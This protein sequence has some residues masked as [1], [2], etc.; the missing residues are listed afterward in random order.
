MGLKCGY[1]FFRRYVLGEKKPP[2]AALAFGRSDDEAKNVVYDHKIET[3]ETLGINE[4]Q[5][6][7]AANFEQQTE[8]VEDWK[9]DKPGDLKDTGVRLM[10]AWREQIAID[11]H[12]VMTQK[13][14][15]VPI[16]YRKRE[17]G[18]RSFL[19]EGVLDLVEDTAAV[20]VITDNKTSAQKWGK[21]RVQ[22]STQALFYGVAA[23]RDEDLRA[24]EVDPNQ[25]HFHVAVKSKTPQLQHP[26]QDPDMVRRTDRQERQGAVRSMV[27]F[28]TAVEA[29]M[30]ND[31][32]LP[33]RSH[34]M[35]S[36]RWCGWWADCEKAFGGKV[37]E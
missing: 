34:F 22:D 6:L 23:E 4:C 2:T 35:C 19:F 1:Q 10:G 7:F 21:G 20:R 15:A 28:H 31:S 24:L 30:A 17:G 18:E 12:P 5:E 3:G 25:M 27:L 29:N 14:F 36:R 13:K 8:E 33:N 11:T 9:G 26:S 32:F 37:R 16:T